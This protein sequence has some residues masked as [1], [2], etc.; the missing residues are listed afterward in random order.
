MVARARHG[1]VVRGECV[2]HVDARLLDF[3]LNAALG[4]GDFSFRNKHLRQHDSRRGRH[5]HRREQV[6][7]FDVGNFDIGGHDR[8]GDV[9]H[10]ADH[11]GEQFGLCEFGE[12]RADGEWGFGLPHEDAGG[13]IGAFGAAGAHNAEHDP[14]HAL[15]HI[16]HDAEVV[17]DG[18]QGGDED[19]DG[20][21]LEG[22]NDAELH[23]RTGD[24][25]D[26]DCGILRPERA[27]EELAAGLGV[28]EQSVD[29]VTG[30]LKGLAE[31]RFEDQEGEEELEAQ[32]PRE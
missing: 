17:E 2:D 18:E 3:D 16:L 7:D 10:A 6:L 29:G 30:G 28:F 12:E 32:S 26:G 8:A 25:G 5:D 13:D 11:D 14:S 1:V 31:I 21:N 19:D 9:R 22:E 27:K 24:S 4:F 23:F 20:K 15:D